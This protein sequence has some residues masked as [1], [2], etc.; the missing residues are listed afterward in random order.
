M[1][2]ITPAWNSLV[3]SIKTESA[4]ISFTTY[5]TIDL[6]KILIH[7]VIITSWIAEICILYWRDDVTLKYSA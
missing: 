6:I 4:Q 1:N 7:T 5:V 2:L 3:R